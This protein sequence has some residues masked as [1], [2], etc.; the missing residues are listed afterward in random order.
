M[1]YYGGV[2][3]AKLCAGASMLVDANESVQSDGQV[4][5][6]NRL[7]DVEDDMALD[8]VA[9]GILAVRFVKANMEIGKIT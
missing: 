5:D 7:N 1:R 4:R 8:M 2:D 6:A 3:R 9:S